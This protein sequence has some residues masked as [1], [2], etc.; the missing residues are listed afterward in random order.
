MPDEQT[1]FKVEDIVIGPPP[2]PTWYIVVSY[3]PG[4]QWLGGW[5]MCKE[6]YLSRDRAGEIA[7][8]RKARGDLYISIWE[9]PGTILMAQGKE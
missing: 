1:L 6:Q 5:A 9:L 7:E 4:A 3:R 8:E 2:R